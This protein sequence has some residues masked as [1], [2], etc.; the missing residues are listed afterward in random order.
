VVTGS[1]DEAP[2]AVVPVQQSETSDVPAVDAPA[3]SAQ[4]TT[5]SPDGN[6]SADKEQ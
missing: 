6:E 2:E 5:E 4:P 3:A 1:S